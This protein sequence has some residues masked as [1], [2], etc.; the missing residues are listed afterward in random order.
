MSVTG[1]HAYIDVDGVVLGRPPGSNDIALA[2]G[3]AELVSFS[4]A[5]GGCSWLSTHGAGGEPTAVMRHLRPYLPVELV[6]LFERV[7]AAPWQTL[8][9]RALPADS[10]YYWLD[11]QPLRAEIDELERR[12]EQGRL[13]RVDTR[14]NWIALLDV[15]V[16]LRAAW[17]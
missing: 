3:A 15:M 6:A 13:L 10:D 1:R 12:G 2:P 11:D 4:L 8:K 14:R 7:D 16:F 17:R 5:V 9:T